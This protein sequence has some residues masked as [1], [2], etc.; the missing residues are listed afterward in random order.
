MADPNAWESQQTETHQA[1]KTTVQ[2]HLV[3]QVS[4]KDKR[5]IGRERDFFQQVP[6]FIVA[7]YR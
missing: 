4:D 6:E 1:G 3:H 2:Q 5:V 7:A